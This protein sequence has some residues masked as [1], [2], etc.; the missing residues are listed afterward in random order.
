MMQLQSAS[1]YHRAF[2][3]FGAYFDERIAP[4]LASLETERQEVARHCWLIIA[5]ALLVFVGSMWAA[6]AVFQSFALAFVGFMFAGAIIVFGLNWRMEGIYTRVNTELLRGIA[7]YLKLTHIGDATR[8][9]SLEMFR[10]RRLVPKNNMVECGDIIEGVWQ[11]VKFACSEAWLSQRSSDN[12]GDHTVFAGQLFRIDLPF[13]LP[14]SFMLIGRRERFGSRKKPHVGAINVTAE[15][16]QLKPY[17]TVWGETQSASHVL[18][19]H[20]L[21]PKLLDLGRRY[22]KHKMRLWLWRDRVYIAISNGDQLAA[23]SLFSPLDS[24][25]RV[26]KAMIGFS[27]LLRT[28]EA[29]AP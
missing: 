3:G 6:I 7:E 24:Q 13:T 29:F 2:D 17:F 16:R 19:A 26:R 4:P 22:A 20:G 21:V 1:E 11:G 14:E 25:R 18:A 5:G 23:G 28:V 15:V 27:K 9:R 12:R 10:K 8:P